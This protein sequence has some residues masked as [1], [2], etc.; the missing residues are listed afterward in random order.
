MALHF[1]L[2]F[3]FDFAGRQ[4]FASCRPGT[5]RSSASFLQ[6]LLLVLLVVDVALVVVPSGQLRRAAFVTKLLWMS[7]VDGDLQI[8][9]CWRR[10]ARLA[11]QRCRRTHP[12][13]DQSAARLLL[14]PSLG[15][16]APLQRDRSGCAEGTLPP[17]SA[18]CLFVGDP[19]RR[20]SNPLASSPH[21]G[22]GLRMTPAMHLGPG[23]RTPAPVAGA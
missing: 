2:S 21:K 12:G 23:L 4:F 15:P 18:C 17:E 9:A 1:R 8:R 7:Q 5:P 16:P 20:G 3:S 10:M 11:Y 6:L 22:L 14:Q 19:S 13:V